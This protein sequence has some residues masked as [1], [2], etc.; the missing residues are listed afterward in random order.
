MASWNE[1]MRM[2]TPVGLLAV[3]LAG[4]C[5]GPNETTQLGLADVETGAQVVSSIDGGAEATPSARDGGA[6]TISTKLAGDSGVQRVWPA[7]KDLGVGDGRDVIT[8]GD[9]WM[10]MGGSSGIHGGLVSASG[11]RPYRGYGRGGAA[12]LDGTIPRQYRSA[13]SADADIKTVVMTAGGI[14]MLGGR[15][16]A[17]GFNEIAAGLTTLWSEMAKDG[18]EDVIYFG[19]TRSTRNDQPVNLYN[20]IM[21]RA[22]AEAP[23]RCYFIDG[24]VL[25][26]RK[27]ADGI[28]PTA[29]GSRALGA[30]AYQLMVAE[31]M[32]R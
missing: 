1:R 8:L 11:N 13:K 20:T 18:V 12:L 32:R 14:D 29:E 5:A 3:L 28:H 23:L 2:V 22:C 10:T 7:H 15:T 27:T 31:G 26:D 21:S 16:T 19:Y 6:K 30:A 17:A 9:S 24:D 25:I 4:A